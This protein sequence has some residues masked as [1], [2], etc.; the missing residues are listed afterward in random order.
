MHYRSGRN[1]LGRDVTNRTVMKTAMDTGS[2]V[3]FGIAIMALYMALDKGT[4]QPIIVA[5]VAVVLGIVIK[6]SRHI[7][8]YH[9]IRDQQKID[10]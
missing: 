7:W 1:R 3:F 4:V 10:H 8:N 5:V 2:L 6:A 9:L